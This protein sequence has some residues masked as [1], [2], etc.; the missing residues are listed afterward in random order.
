MFFVQNMRMSR[1]LPMCFQHVL[2][3]CVRV[4]VA[5]LRTQALV[6]SA[7]MNKRTWCSR[8]LADYAYQV[9]M[10]CLYIHPATY[11][12]QIA[13]DRMQLSYHAEG[14]TVEFVCLP[15]A[16]H[17]VSGLW[18]NLKKQHLAVLS[19]EN[20]KGLPTATHS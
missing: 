14:Q 6:I 2:S 7:G 3:D 4:F 17:V 9:F 10:L 8:Q 19:L 12:V 1:M 13:P 18:L 16:V 11:I 20:E 5:L 15:T